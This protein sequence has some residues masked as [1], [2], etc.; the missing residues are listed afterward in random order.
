MTLLPYTRNHM[1]LEAQKRKFSST[2]ITMLFSF[3]VF[4]QWRF[5]KY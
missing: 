3:F 1:R 4:L 2:L 5:Q